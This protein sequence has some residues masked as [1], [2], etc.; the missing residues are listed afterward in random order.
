MGLKPVTKRS[1]KHTLLRARRAAF[2]H[3]VQPIKKI[4]RIAGII[5]RWS[6]TGEGS[7]ESG[8]PL[9]T[10]AKE[11]IDTMKTL[12]GGVC[13]DWEGPAMEGL[14]EPVGSVLHTRSVQEY[15]KLLN[16]AKG[17]RPNAKFGYYAIPLG[18]YYDRD[19]TWL[20]EAEGYKVIME[21]S[22]VLFPSC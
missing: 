22:E 2:E 16:L 11:S 18:R 5:R 14:K 3:I 15:L 13:I 9:P 20:A 17:L 6:K 10:A 12:G 1:A 4:G 19:A 21:Q 8:G 7:E